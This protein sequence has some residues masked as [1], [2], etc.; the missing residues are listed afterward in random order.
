MS[1]DVEV[2]INRLI[3]NI[4]V[5]FADTPYPGENIGDD[6]EVG[7][8]VGKKWKDVTVEDVNSNDYL[9]FFKLEALRYYLPSYLITILS[10][11]DLRLDIR[12]ALIR[13]FDPGENWKIGQA[14]P[15]AR[16]FSQPERTAIALFF[17]NYKQVF[18]PSQGEPFS[19][20]EKKRREVLARTIESWRQYD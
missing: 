9:P 11:P 6:T 13:F 7:R 18:P 12:L 5:A 14:V 10:H 15:L 8:F 1:P 4:E 3:E 17:E 20:V 19:S 16:L 2:L